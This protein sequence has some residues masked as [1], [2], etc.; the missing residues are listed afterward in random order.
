MTDDEA[1]E[2]RYEPARRERRDDTDGD[3]W[4][5]RIAR[6][7]QPGVGVPELSEHEGQLC[8][9]ALAVRGERDPAWPAP[10]Q[11]H[12]QVLFEASNLMAHRGLCHAQLTR[13]ARE[14]RVACRSLEGLQR[15][16]RRQRQRPLAGGRWFAGDRPSHEIS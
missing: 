8:C 13:G 6:L 11:C 5:R 7:T 2:P 3:G 16:E 14:A 1:A 4:P 10:E 12:A 15:V 9:P